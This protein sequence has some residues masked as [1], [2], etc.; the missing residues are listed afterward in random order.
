VTPHEALQHIDQYGETPIFECPN[1]HVESGKA[2]IP[3]DLWHC[4]AC[5]RW[6][7]VASLPRPQFKPTPVHRS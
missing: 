2:C 1:C 4:T 6:G 3:L 5:D 7:R